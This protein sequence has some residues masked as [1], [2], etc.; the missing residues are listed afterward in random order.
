MRSYSID[1]GCNVKQSKNVSLVPHQMPYGNKIFMPSKC[2]CRRTA[3]FKRSN[4][5]MVHL[6]A[7]KKKFHAIVS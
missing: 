5:L 4:E 7:P 1:S 2:V 6:V 3:T